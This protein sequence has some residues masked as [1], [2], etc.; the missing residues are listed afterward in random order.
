MIMTKVTVVAEYIRGE[1]KDRVGDMLRAAD[2]IRKP[3][4]LRDFITKYS[5]D[6]D[7]P[8]APL[9]DRILWHIDPVE[10][11]SVIVQAQARLRVSV[12]EI[13]A[14]DDTGK[15]HIVQ[16]KVDA[17]DFNH[18]LGTKLFPSDRTTG[19]V[20]TWCGDT[21]TMAD[22]FAEPDGE[23]NPIMLDLKALAV[24]AGDLK[25]GNSAAYKKIA[26]YPVRKRALFIE[27][28]QADYRA[29]ISANALTQQAVF[30][31]GK[32]EAERDALRIENGGLKQ[33]VEALEART[34]D[35]DPAVFSE[36]VAAFKK[37]KTEDAPEA[38]AA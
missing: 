16:A 27:Q 17:G 14:T 19:A 35:F 24:A 26:L 30:K 18:L 32:A 9:K 1:R 8:T 36:M 3:R 4:T 33:Q 6:N 21:P 20:P 29:L 28:K 10:R 15:E 7:D 2:S 22:E 38:V 34:M 25:F 11:R 23:N 37:T 13:K 31:Q 12:D 5:R